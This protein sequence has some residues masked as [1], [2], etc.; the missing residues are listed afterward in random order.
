MSTATQGLVGSPF[1]EPVAAFPRLCQATVVLGR[2]FSHHYGA[3]PSSE[4]TTEKYKAATELYANARALST[5]ILEQVDAEQDF[6]S[7]ASAL[8]LTFSTL[9]TLCDEYS[10]P[11]GG[12]KPV[13]GSAMQVQAI[14]GL[15][16]VSESILNFVNHV[17]ANAQVLPDLDRISPIIMNALYSAAAN[18]AWMVRE[19]GGELYQNGLDAIRNC[20]RRLGVRWRNAAEYVRI[21]EAQEF[22]YAVG[23]AS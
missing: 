19:S 6:F 7:Y 10:C 13:E 18:Y 17:N 5:Q 21:L 1:A 3:E 22:S 12:C 4:N 20:L 9:C 15:K 16:T 8:A 23:S 14:E 2:V 11:K